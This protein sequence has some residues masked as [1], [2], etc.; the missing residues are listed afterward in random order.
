MTKNNAS[1]RGRPEKRDEEKRNSV[2]QFR[3]TAKERK[4]LEAAAKKAR[5]TLSDW[6]RAQTL[7]LVNSGE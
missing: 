5:K 3:C 4:T 1:R 7:R 6:L 2:L